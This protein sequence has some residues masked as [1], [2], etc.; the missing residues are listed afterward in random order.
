MKITFLDVLAY[1][2]IFK[3]ASKTMTFNPDDDSLEKIIDIFDFIGKILNIYLDNY[4]YEDNKGITYLKTK[5]SDETCFRKDKDKT[6]NTILNEKAKY[7]C[8]VLLQI[9][10]V[11]YN[12]NENKNYYPQVFLQS[13]RYTFI[14]NNEL[15]LVLDFTDT[16]TEFES[17]EEFNENTK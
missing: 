8:R 2:N 9:E 10:S 11:Y 13:C 6:T 14:A 15:I 4:S 12:N 1:Y 17:E 3:D 16:E 5:V 7:T